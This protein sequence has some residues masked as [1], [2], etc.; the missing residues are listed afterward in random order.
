MGGALLGQVFNFLA[1]LLPIIGGETGQLA[2]L[3]LPLAIATVLARTSLLGFQSRYLTTPEDL[4]DTATSMSFVSLTGFTSICAAVAAIL[5]FFTDDY[6]EI[7]A[8][9]ALLIFTNG[10]YLMAVA[11]A[12]QERRMTLYS[13]ARLIYGIINVTLTSAVVWLVPMTPGLIIVSA[14]NPAIAAVIILAK[15]DNKVI[16]TLRREARSLT[17]P[18]HRAY[19][20]SSLHASGAMFVSECGFQIQGFITPFLGQ[21]QEV[22][23]VVVR[24]T[25]GFGTLAQQ[26]IAP[27]F[28][29]RIAENIRNGNRESAKQWCLYTAFCGLGLGLV[30]ALIQT[31]ALAL[32]QKNSQQLTALV[33]LI[34]ALYCMTT[35]ATNISLK[36]PLMKGFDKLFLWWSIARLTLILIIL[37]TTGL[38]L[39]TGIVVIQIISSLA[40]LALS[41][42]STD[43]GHSLPNLQ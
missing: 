25:G 18:R 9:T 19:L 17:D 14:A 8:W 16:P 29:M 32:T 41:L 2:Y 39:L 10:L 21:Y 33:L 24:L 37:S 42:K 5:A 43:R 27:G 40:F 6:C 22:W 12:T 7:A 23:A 11:I 3:M 1:M 15:S 4:K 31:S 26:V 35:I 30:C 13:S 20:R 36:I 34:T 28:E 38:Q